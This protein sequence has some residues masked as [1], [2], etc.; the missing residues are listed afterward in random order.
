MKMNF[1]V[2]RLAKLAGLEGDT[3]NHVLLE[4][5]GRS[6]ESL[7]ELGNQ[8]KRDE[9]GEEDEHGHQLA[10][11]DDDVLEIDEDVIREE[12]RKMKRERIAEAKLR[13]V[14]KNELADILSVAGYDQSGSWVY[15]DNKPTKS[16]KGRVTMGA[17][18]V[19]FK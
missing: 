11:G 9:Q 16:Q 19:G 5:T 1:N 8:R 12:I 18:G 2:N 10:E 3:D 15:G 13:D 7:T 6:A 17:L 14:I 4:S